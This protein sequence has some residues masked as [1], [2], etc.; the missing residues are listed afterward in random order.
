MH[1]L[2]RASLGFVGFCLVAFVQQSASGSKTTQGKFFVPS[3]HLEIPPILS[4]LVECR[5]A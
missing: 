2:I 3:F 1:A 5:S 4:E